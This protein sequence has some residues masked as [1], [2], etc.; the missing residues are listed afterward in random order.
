[1]DEANR[2]VRPACGV[3][4]GGWR[5]IDGVEGVPCLEEV[6]KV[7]CCGRPRLKVLVA[8]ASP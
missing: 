6:A 2:A 5:C 3:A 4:E 1:M 7:R 8:D